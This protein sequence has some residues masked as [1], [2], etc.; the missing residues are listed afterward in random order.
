MEERKADAKR[1]LQIRSIVREL[2]QACSD[3]IR[4]IAVTTS[5]LTRLAYAIEYDCIDPTALSASLGVR[6]VAGLHQNGHPVTR[7]AGIFYP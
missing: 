1:I 5:T 4:S 7:R 6:Q 2:P 3:F